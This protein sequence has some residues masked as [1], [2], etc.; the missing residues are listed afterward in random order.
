M[1]SQTKDC[2]LQASSF[3]KNLLVSNELRFLIALQLMLK[4]ASGKWVWHCGFTD[5]T[6][7]GGSPQVCRGPR[8]RCCPWAPPSLL[9][10]P[11]GAVS[12]RKL[13]RH[14]CSLAVSVSSLVFIPSSP[15][16]T[17]EVRPSCAQSDP[18]TLV[19]PAITFAYLQDF[20][21]SQPHFLSFT[22]SSSV[23]FLKETVLSEG[24]G[25]CPS[26]STVPQGSKVP[27]KGPT[28]N[29]LESWLSGPVGLLP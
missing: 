15:L 5:H 18:G 16:L 19:F 25:T 27:G 20:V 10:R 28:R 13:W 4:I 24:L 9:T 3:C 2:Q 1:D 29:S 7:T 8:T 23:V 22:L 6:Y 17:N 12:A 14:S 11:P 26:P 21:L